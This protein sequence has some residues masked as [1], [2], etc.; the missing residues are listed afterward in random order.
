MKVN[1]IF[2]EPYFRIKY[3]KYF[4]G[5]FV[6]KTKFI[7][8]G[9]N[10]NHSMPTIKK[11]IDMEIIPREGE[12]LYFKNDNIDYH[13]KISAISHNYCGDKPEINLLLECF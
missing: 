2:S 6:L 8:D 1:L 7:P 9:Y 11:T 10:K 3:K 12:L 13:F 5:L 4:Y